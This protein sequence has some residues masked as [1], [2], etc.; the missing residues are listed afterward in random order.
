MQ[1]MVNG[2]TLSYSAAGNGVP[3]VLIHGYPLSARMWL[4]QR[5]GLADAAQMLAPDLWGFGESTPVAKATIGSFADEVRALMDERGIDRAVICGLSMGGYITFEFCD[6]YP[7][8]VAGVI[9]ANT[10][11]TPDTP[12][13]KAGRDKSA[14]LAR[15][16]GVEAIIAAMLPKL[17]APANYAQNPALVAEVGEIMRQ[18]TVPGIVS[19]LGAMRD[20]PDYTPLLPRI[21]RPALVIGGTDDQLF[22]RAEFERMANGLPDV[23]LVLLPQAGHLSNL[24]Q[25]D[26]FND[27][28][29]QFLKRVG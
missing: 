4:P 28:V 26:L 11:S 18:S 3:L 8:R 21:T 17:L 13:G 24:E 9:L 22:P 12:E 5:S 29:K 10:K 19:A 15:T 2:Q 20:R 23:R 16:Q 7:D 6:R 27:A 1:T 25:P 14:E